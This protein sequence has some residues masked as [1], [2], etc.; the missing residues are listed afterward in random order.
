MAIINSKAAASKQSIDATLPEWDQSLCS[1]AA[2]FDAPLPARHLGEKCELKENAPLT[3]V[4]SIL[5]FQCRLRS[6]SSEKK[7]IDG[8]PACPPPPP[9][10]A[11]AVL[12]A[13]SWMSDDTLIYN[14]SAGIITF[15]WTECFHHAAW[16]WRFNWM[17]V[18]FALK[19]LP[20]CSKMLIHA[21]FW[22]LPMALWYPTM[23]LGPNWRVP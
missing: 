6:N 18:P 11:A 10:W 21:C 14:D 1:A 23:G 5:F 9:A 7:M 15:S 16:R 3:Q 20:E 17:P 19:C 12:S 8:V 22:H 13:I 4:L 2:S